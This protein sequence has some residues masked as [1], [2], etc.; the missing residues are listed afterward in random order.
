MFAT[1]I[2]PSATS[3]GA[4]RPSRG[5]AWGLAALLAL[6]GLAGVAVAHGGGG[7][8]R[9]HDGFG[10]RIAGDIDTAAREFTAIVGHRQEATVRV[11][12]D[13]IITRNGEPAAFEDLA[14][15]DSFRAMGRT[16]SRRPFVFEARALGAF[17]G[18]APPG[19]PPA[20]AMGSIA[21]IDSEAS[22]FV[23]RSSRHGDTTVSV[24]ET[25]RIVKDGAMADFA[26]LAVDD[27]ASVRGRVETTDAGDEI[28][29]AYMIRAHTPGT[30]P[31]GGRDHDGLHGQISGDP[32]AETREFTASSHGRELTVRVTAEATIT[33]NGEPATFEDLADGDYFRAMGRVVSNEPFVF[34]ATAVGA[35][36]GTAP[37]HGPRDHSEGTIASIDAAALTFV[38][39]S[40][41]SG[42]TTVAVSDATKISKDGA[43][44]DFGALAV[45][46][47]ASV[48]GRRETT[49]DGSTILRAF[50]V[51]ATTPSGG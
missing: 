12:E 35:F 19:G 40:E 18:T 4:R 16:V 20:H 30:G 3:S 49:D 29:V 21:S 36:D 32:N 46:D 9:D 7:G 15:G 47:A 17:D 31:G 44:A 33:R 22:T 43:A 39:R 23:L 50:F 27:F 28:L 34:E 2:R 37:P 8:G 25:T 14:V 26:A 41:R 42:D 45:G 38:L 48:R 51:R 13:A 1:R 5:F 24:V 6:S 10:G 11:T